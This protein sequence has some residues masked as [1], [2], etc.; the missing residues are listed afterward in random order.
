MSGKIQNALLENYM[1]NKGSNPFAGEIRS[2]N[3]T[4][5]RRKDCHWSL[6][7]EGWHKA[8]FDGVAK[9]NQ[10]AISSGGVIINYHRYGIAMVTFPLGHQTN[11]YVE[12]CVALQ[13]TKLA[14]E[15]GVKILWLEG[16]SNNIIKCIRGEHP[17]S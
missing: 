14:K 10:G 15:V 5:K 16:D 6:P 2:S 3:D 1:F 9:G 13:I 8:N 17:P 7:P 11:Y 4:Q 12:A